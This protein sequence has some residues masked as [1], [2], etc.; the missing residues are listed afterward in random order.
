MK[1]NILIFTVLVLIC[2]GCTANYKVEI[3]DDE[4]SEITKV[5]ES[6]NIDW[7]A[8]YKIFDDNFSSINDEKVTYRQ[9]VDQKFKEKESA[10]K[11]FA[12]LDALYSKK[13]ISN[14][15]ELGIQYS[16]DY[17]INQYNDSYIASTCFRYF[18][19]LTSD[20]KYILSTSKGADCFTEY[21]KLDSL[22]IELSTNHKVVKH[23]ADAVNG[24]AYYWNIDRTN[25]SDKSIYIELYKDKYEK[26]YNNEK[27]KKQFAEVIRTIL[28]VV[29]CI[30]ISLFIV[31]IILRKKANRN[32]R[33]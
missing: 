1:R 2:S 19:F 14:E 9:Y 4:V 12:S 17:P 11:E 28:I 6:N 21:K 33:I 23:N 16:Y 18:N 7:D 10:L 5:V 15:N 32:N 26:G 20:N 24:Y 31:I 27:R 22:T 13:I 29:L 30:A 25:Y 8:E 3:Y